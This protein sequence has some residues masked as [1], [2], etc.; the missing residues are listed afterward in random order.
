M[1]T[2]RRYLKPVNSAAVVLSFL[3]LGVL[4]ATGGEPDAVPEDPT[5][6]QPALIGSK[7]PDLTLKTKTGKAF[8]LNKAVAETP[9]VIIFYRGGWCPYC[10]RHLAEL[11]KIEG[12]LQALGYQV[13]AISADKPE[14]VATTLDKKQ[15]AYTLLSDND[16]K[17]A[18]ALGIA[19]RVEEALFS[20]YKNEYGLDLE[21]HSGRTHHMLPVPAVFIVDSDRVIR[22][23]YVNPDYK[24]RVSG[25]VIM[26]AARWVAGDHNNGN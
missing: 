23:K 25:E 14:K 11:R 18:K 19:F 10:N 16:L 13:L 20:K 8:D 26:A 9:A 21:E 17:A 22:F 24:V 1:K 2:A 12:D 15:F 6:V 3:M 4:P 5:K 7:L